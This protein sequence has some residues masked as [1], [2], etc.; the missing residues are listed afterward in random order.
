MTSMLPVI[1]AVH[2]HPCQRIAYTGTG[3]DLSQPRFVTRL[4]RDTSL[5]QLSLSSPYTSP[6][7]YSAKYSG[8]Y[9]A[10]DADV[11]DHNHESE[12]SDHICC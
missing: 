8:Y 5:E 9:F 1:E 10:S 2:Y 4:A 11:K 6:Q 7:R 12:S 3:M